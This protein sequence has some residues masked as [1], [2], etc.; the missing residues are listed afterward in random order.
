MP[1][2][3]LAAR[4]QT[5]ASTQDCAT[6]QTPKG[7]YETAASFEAKLLAAP[8][9]GDVAAAAASALAAAAALTVESS[10]SDAIAYAA[11]V[12]A[13]VEQDDANRSWPLGGRNAAAWQRTLL[14]QAHRE[15]RLVQAAL[16][17]A[18]ALSQAPPPGNRPPVRP[19]LD[20]V[21]LRLG[22]QRL[23]KLFEES[24]AV[25][26]DAP[27]LGEDSGSSRPS[28]V[29]S[30]GHASQHRQ[31]AEAPVQE[32]AA[33]RPQ[34]TAGGYEGSDASS[35]T[36]VSYTQNPIASSA[37]SKRSLRAP[38]APTSV[39]KTLCKA[40]LTAFK[41]D[42]TKRGAFTAWELDVADRLARTGDV[43]PLVRHLAE[44]ELHMEQGAR[45]RRLCLAAESGRQDA[46]REEEAAQIR[47]ERRELAGEWGMA[48]RSLLGEGAVLNLF[49]DGNL[50]WP[51][52]R[53]VLGSMSEIT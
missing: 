39:R 20:S 19:T 6:A 17:P 38:Q 27:T 32:E 41:E 12:A 28:Q 47:A 51:R 24:S 33:S 4:P 50:S 16:R 23:P 10:D 29:R 22:V 53:E 30:E 34:R 3:R 37:S 13:H 25:S 7:A 35:E 26:N 36:P 44:T 49:L 21:H 15:R 42:A 14:G 31:T 18:E 5:S 11:A 45:R 1:P 8:R 2:P 40:L 43:V 48:K 9:G 46:Y 52:V